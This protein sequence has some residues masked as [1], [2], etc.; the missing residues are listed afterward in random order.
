MKGD[1][2]YGTA[3]GCAKEL[4]ACLQLPEDIA[5]SLAEFGNF[6]VAKNT[7]KS[8]KSAKHMLL[9]CSKETKTNME[10][11]L[12]E[13]EIL[14]FIDWL[15]R[16]RG[17]KG[18]S[19]NSYL[20]GIRQMHVVSGMDPPTFRTGLVKLVLKGVTNRDNIKSRSENL[21]G[22][23]PITT[24]VMILFKR[25][26]QQLEL[27]DKDKAMI[28][29]VATV[30]FA[31][32]FRISEILCKTESTFDP[33]FDLLG[34]D[35]SITYDRQGQATAHFTLKCP[36][37]SKSSRATTVD[38]F[39]ND[40]AIC[41]IAALKDWD[42][43]CRHAK[44]LPFFRFQDGTPLT[45]AKL[46]CILDKTLGL[47]TDKKIGKFTTHSFRIG[48]ASEL[49]RLGYSD[50]EIKAAGR[51]SSRAFE[52]YL[53]LKRTK[54]SVVAKEISKLTASKRKL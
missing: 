22:R 53:K 14:I 40:G 38:L 49:G 39:Q 8:Y 5:K 37:E 19:I 1:K 30:A 51:W 9:K 18:T 27:A 34:S 3:G 46:N 35:V 10:L 16:H 20:S 41:P 13:R 47:Y 2:K 12:A 43:G 32:A 4:L 11:P 24:N 17:L 44:H 28:W 29:A 26:V 15:A 7:W 48:L 54:R 31:G 25:L 23:L 45:G 52:A 50:E 42:G 6:G 21:S 33:D 36:K